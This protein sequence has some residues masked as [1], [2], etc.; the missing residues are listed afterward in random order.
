MKNI[1]YIYILLL[2]PSLVFTQE[3]SLS[4]EQ[5]RVSAKE[6]WPSFKKLSYQQENRDLVDKTLNKNYLPKITLSGSASYQSEVVVFPEIGIPG[7]SGFFP[8]FPN[9]NY[10]ADINLT[11]VI[12]DGGTTKNIKNLQNASIT[13]EESKIEI[14]NYNLME[15]INSLYLNILL[16]EENYK[17]LIVTKE[18]IE[19]NSE[20]I[21]SAYKN[22]M[23]L[24]TELNKIYSEKIN[25]E[26]QILNS[27]TSKLNL[28]ESLSTLTGLDITINTAFKTPGENSS[29]SRMLPQLKSFEAQASLNQASLDKDFRN[30]FPKLSLFANGGYGRPGYNFMNTDLHSYGIVGVNFSWNVIDWGIYGKQKEKTEVTK[31]I[32]EASREAF[33]KQNES[34]I[35]KLNNDRGNI[36]DQIKMDKKLIEIKVEVKDMSWSQ[37]KNGSIKSNDYLKDF[38][39]LKRSKQS[40]EVNKIKLIQIDLAIEHLKGVEY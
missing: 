27:E 10:R 16:L 26:K 5:C 12:Y 7:M 34:E 8:T 13:L 11:Q 19:A 17:I 30:R 6:N 25:L 24:K 33:N 38:N 35:T 32:I 40:L 20:I 29:N 23:V 28:I 36:S 18:E 14:E 9:D 2:L 31:K 15:Q 22:G 4:I 21:E 3:L 1:K 37:F 39:N